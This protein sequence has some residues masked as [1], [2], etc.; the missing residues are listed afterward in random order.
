M[1][2]ILLIVLTFS[3]FLFSTLAYCSPLPTG[4][5]DDFEN[6][7]ALA[8]SSGH[9]NAAKVCLLVLKEL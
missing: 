2:D 7:S 1:G 4:A 8:S 3:E 6:T 5:L 9:I